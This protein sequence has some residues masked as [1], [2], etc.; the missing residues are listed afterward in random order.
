MKRFAQIVL[1][2]DDPEIIRQYEAY[3]ANP[4]PEVLEGSARCGVLR[5]FI[6]R[7]GRHL[8]MFME[9]PDDFDLER[10]M[11]KYMEHPRAR[12][13]DTLMRTFQEA[14]PGAPEGATWVLM[15]EVFAFEPGRG[16]DP[17]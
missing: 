1:L 14:P 10:D 7:Y 12:E 3:H 16:G 9:T 11:P 2:K 15:K 6:Y 5:T 13:W 17:A 8:F 4:W